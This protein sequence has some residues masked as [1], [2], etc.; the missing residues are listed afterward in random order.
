MDTPLS[1]KTHVEF[2]PA[3]LAK[4]TTQ[5]KVYEDGE[6]HSPLSSS[7]ETVAVVEHE[8]AYPDGGYGWVVVLG[9]VL[10]SS[11]TVGWSYVLALCAHHRATLLI[12]SFLLC[13]VVV[14]CR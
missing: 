4:A 5:S 14:V 11:T 9:C 10:F 7:A 6:S 3:D 2:S 8:E 12:S 13:P 1:E